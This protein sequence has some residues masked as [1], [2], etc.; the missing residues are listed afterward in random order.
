VLRPLHISCRFFVLSNAA[1]KED[2]ST[3]PFSS[4]ESAV[5]VEIDDVKVDEMPVKLEFRFA[6]SAVALLV[7]VGATAPPPKRLENTLGAAG[8]AIDY[9][10]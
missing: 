5:A 1:V 3:I 2:V 9:L 8:A 10:S 6:I 4:G 7:S